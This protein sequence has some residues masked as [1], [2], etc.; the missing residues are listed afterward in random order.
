M[1]ATNDQDH[2]QEKQV[3][4]LLD[5]TLTFFNYLKRF[6]YIKP[7][8]RPRDESHLIMVNDALNVLLNLVC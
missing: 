2:I 6:A 7:S 5:L 3:F 8:L 4:Q 1:C